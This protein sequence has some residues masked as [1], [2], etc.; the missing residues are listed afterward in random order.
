MKILLKKALRAIWRNK[1]TYIACIVLIM[2][3]VMMYVSFGIAGTALQTAKVEFYK[4]TNF[5]DAF[6]G[7]RG[8]SRAQADALRIDGIA[9]VSARVVLDAQVYIEDSDAVITL[10]LLSRNHDPLNQIRITGADIADDLDILMNQSFLDAWGLEA[11]DEVSLIINNRL[12]AF[13]IRGTFSSP[14]YLYI[15]DEGGSI[16]PDEATFNVAV[17]SENTLLALNDNLFNDLSFALAPGIE[18]SDVEFALE[19]A[20]QRFGLLSLIAQEDQTSNAI[21]TMEVNYIV[22]IG[23]SVPMMFILM[24]II[25]LYL[26]LKR[27]IEQ[28][29]PQIGTL[30]AFGY[31]KNQILV[32]YAFYGA[33]TGAIGG[34]LGVLLGILASDGFLVLFAEFFKLPNLVRAG[35]LQFSI[36]G[37]LMAVAGGV[38]G[39]IMG[40]KSTLKLQPAES[41]R[42][43][44]PNVKHKV[45][46][47][48]KWLP[49]TAQ[50]AIRSM[51]RNKVRSVF[52]VFGMM[53]SFGFLTFM[54][55]FSTMIDDVML[56]TYNQIQVYDGKV[57][58]HT[59]VRNAAGEIERIPGI[60]YAEAIIEIPTEVSL[61][62]RSTTTML[63]GLAA[64][65]VLLRIYDTDRSQTFPPPGNG[66][67]LISA[68][69]RELGARPGDYVTINERQVRVVEIVQQGMGAGAYLEKKFLSDIMEFTG[70]S[71]AV[72]FHA[73]DLSEIKRIAREGTNVRSLDDQAHTRKLMEDMLRPYTSM[74][75]IFLV[76]G[77]VIA[78]AICYNTASIALME[79]KREYAT[80]RVIGMHTREVANILRFEYWVLG[81]CGILLGIPLP[82]MM[83]M[84]IN[85]MMADM[86]LFSLSTHI[87]L[88]AYLTGLVC[89]LAAIYLSNRSNVRNVRKMEMVTVLKERE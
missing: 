63:T 55:S 7:V 44:V 73:Y 49:T 19:D 75:Y 65:S 2:L 32:S 83:L 1:K 25:I 77:I 15:I 84:A 60:T 35:T 51:S 41:M 14:E 80:L 4:E 64:E 29:R 47:G 26:M 24:S 31:T 67:I 66:I 88:Q 53:F 76:L 20:L 38:A 81:A 48:L 62:N 57:R 68:L 71:T 61:S 50:M 22:S 17:V 56:S 72:L 85:N 16:L 86:D 78:F 13:T 34:I 33:L 74:F 52:I 70:G 5:A 28:E 46:H 58:F 82:R 43:A 27:I 9:D 42:P 69:A 54:A 8:I 37:L 3:G 30:K 23:N 11:G 40:A 21:L 18:F 79:R 87:P 10:R 6:A 59:P 89:T 45:R 36:V 39:S 12:I